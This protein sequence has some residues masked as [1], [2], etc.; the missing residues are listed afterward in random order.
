MPKEEVALQAVM[1]VA[2]QDPHI[3]KG[4]VQWVCKKR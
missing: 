1:I 3:M 2:V 4:D